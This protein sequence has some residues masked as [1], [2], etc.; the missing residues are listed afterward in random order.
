MSLYPDSYYAASLDKSKT[1]SSTLNEEHS[2]D[3]CVIGGGFT[4]KLHN[5]IEPAAKGNTII[6]GPNHEKYPE[7][8]LMLDEEIAYII[9]DKFDLIKILDSIENYKN[10]KEKSI[11]FVLKNKGATE[12]VYKIITETN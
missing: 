10:I 7:A 3:L 2:C 6:F 8:K 9:K 11:N 12:V 5:I 1:S 4:G